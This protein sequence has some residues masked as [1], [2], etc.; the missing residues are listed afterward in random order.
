[1]SFLFGGFSEVA[2]VA[3]VDVGFTVVPTGYTGI[4]FNNIIYESSPS[5]FATLTGIFTAE[6]DGRYYY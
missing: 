2:V 5:I 3:V 1:M 4:I 6:S